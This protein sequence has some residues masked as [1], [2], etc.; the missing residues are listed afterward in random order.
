MRYSR[1]P[2][3]RSAVPL[4][5]DQELAALVGCIISQFAL[6][7]M[8]VPRLLAKL[9]GMRKDD[10]H[11]VVGVFRAFSNRID[12]LAEVIKRRAEGSHD[13]I[14][15]GYFKGRLK[16]ANTIRNRYAHATYAGGKGKIKLIPFSGDHNRAPEIIEIS[17][18]SVKADLLKIAT[19]NYELTMWA[20]DQVP[21][22][23]WRQL[24]PE[25]R[26]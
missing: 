21:E 15:Y 24:P 14:I 25:S 1:S 3:K 9:T 6:T 26:A 19:I 4:E 5:G 13:R 18:K 7:E 10:A 16:E 23:L 8:E 12:L 20:M 2:V 22:A 17:P 11:A